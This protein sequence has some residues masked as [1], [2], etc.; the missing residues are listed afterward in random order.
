MTP[1]DHY[2]PNTT[3]HHCHNLQHYL[4]NVTKYF[5]SNTQ[6]LFLPGLHHLHTDL[7]IQNVH[8]VSLIANDT[9]Q[10]TVVI[11]CN[12]SI[13]ITMTN[14][15]GLTMVKIVIENCEIKNNLSDIDHSWIFRR[16]GMILSHCYNVQLQDIT[17]H[18]SDQL[19][20]STILAIN[21]LGISSFIN[22][23][24]FEI[25]IMYN[26]VD[27]DDKYNKL[28]IE[29]YQIPSSP[30][31]LNFDI[32]ITIYLYQISYKVEIEIYNT[33]LTTINTTSGLF[34]VIQTD[35]TFGNFIHFIISV[36]LNR[37]LDFTCFTPRHLCGFIKGMCTINLHLP[38]AYLDIINLKD[39]LL[40]MV[41]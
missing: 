41:K 17:V 4:L 8:N 9:T 26:E 33:K 23:I 40:H 3:C 10:G 2:Y 36:L 31:Y 11:Q 28:L 20:R 13:G 35:N 5:T 38:T 32:G 18:R 16:N 7:I 25:K 22:I 21:M 12:S 14:I 39:Y 6:L 15:T 27:V 24:S 30:K 37:L 19:Y 1:D 34:D 29:N